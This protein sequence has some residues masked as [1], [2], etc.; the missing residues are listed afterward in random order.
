VGQIV[1]ETA[2]GNILS[3]ILIGVL[4]SEVS[5]AVSD[6]PIQ[7]VSSHLSPVVLATL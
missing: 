7:S 2:V 6:T 3:K 1:F 4:P 5:C